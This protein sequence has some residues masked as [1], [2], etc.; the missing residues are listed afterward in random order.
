[1]EVIEVRVALETIARDHVFLARHA[2]ERV[3][4]DL[5][6]LVQPA[7]RVGLHVHAGLGDDSHPSDGGQIIRSL[8]DQSLIRDQRRVPVPLGI[9]E[10][11]LDG[12]RV[13]QVPV[14][15][16]RRVGGP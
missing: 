8:I 12:L 13:H 4:H 9:E 11:D 3:R 7:K 16:H 6:A 10:L 15:V 5:L 14:V 1:M 2:D